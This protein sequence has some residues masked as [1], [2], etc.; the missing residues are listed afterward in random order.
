M[1]RS[2]H[3]RL[4]IGR[5]IVRADHEHPE[6]VAEAFERSDRRGEALATELV[7]DEHDQLGVIGN[8]ELLADRLTRNRVGL[9][10]FDVDS[11]GNDAN[12]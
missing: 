10:A 6:I 5:R 3:G 1:S 12:P 8:P 7:S 9:K 11:I 2:P 4:A